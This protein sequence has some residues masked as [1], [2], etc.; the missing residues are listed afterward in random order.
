M[1][2][3]LNWT[4]GEFLVAW[5]EWVAEFRADPSPFRTPEESLALTPEALAAEC[6]DE[7]RTRIEG[8]RGEYAGTGGEQ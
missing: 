7:L 5:T 8:A 4:R 1:D 2:E 3:I 6:F